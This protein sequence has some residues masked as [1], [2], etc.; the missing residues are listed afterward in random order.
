M[1]VNIILGRSGS[2][3]STAC[4][5][6]IARLSKTENNIYCI[7]PDGFSHKSEAALAGRLGACFEGKASVITFKRL[8][9]RIFE[10]SGRGGLVSLSASA[11]AMLIS[12]AVYLEQKNLSVYKNSAEKFGFSKKMLSQISELVRY[13]VTPDDI[14]KVASQ[15]SGQMLCDKLSDISKIYRRYISLFSKDYYDSEDD[16]YLA[17]AK[18]SGLDYLKD[19]SIFIDEFSDF[20]PSHY[21]MLEVIL[22]RAKNVSFYLCGDN[23]PF[24]ANTFFE[25]ESKT[26]ENIKDMCFRLGLDLK[27]TYMKDN[28]R[29]KK[30][31]DLLALEKNYTEYKVTPYRGESENIN[32]FEASDIFSELEFVAGEINHLCTKE[33]YK[34]S[35][36]CVCAGDI[37]LYEK[38]LDRCFEMYDIAYFKSD[39]TNVSESPVSNM[40]LSAFDILI[41]G[42]TYENVFLYLKSGFSGITDEETD[43]LENYVLEAGIDKSKWLSENDWTYKNSFMS[44]SV[45]TLAKQADQIRRKVIAPL[46][47]LK[48]GIGSKNTVRQGAKSIFE[49]LTSLEADKKISELSEEFKKD[50]KIV[51]SNLFIKAYN[52]IISVLDSLVDIAGDDKIGIKQM[53]NMLKSGFENEYISLIPQTVDE[54]LFCS[55]TDARAADCKLMFLVGTN[56]GEFLFTGGEEGMI[57][58]AEREKLLNLGIT[59]APACKNKITSGRVNEYK[60]LFK[61]D[62]RVYVTY[63]LSDFESNAQNK[64]EMADKIRKI[65]PALGTYS[66]LD[67]KRAYPYQYNS[68][69]PAYLNLCTAMADFASDGE[70]S[71]IWTKVYN[72]LKNDSEYKA[73][74][75]MADK[76]LNFKNIAGPLDNKL[77]SII[78][79]SGINSSVSRLETY[80]KCPFSYFI[81]YTLKA[82]ERKVLKI[83]LND[84]GSIMHNV[85]EEFIKT[86][87]EEKINFKILTEEEIKARLSNITNAFCANILKG[88]AADTKAN[89]YLLERIEKNLCRC[90]LVLVKHFCIGSF[91][92]V[93]CELKFGTEGGKLPAVEIVLDSG[94]KLKIHGVIDRLDKC[95][96]PNGTYYRVVD[97]KSGEKEFHLDKAFHGLDLQLAVYMC[98][99]TL[100]GGKAAAMFYFKIKEPM[101]SKTDFIDEAQAKREIENKMRLDG[102][103]L[104]DDDIISLMDNTG[105]TKSEILPVE[106]LKSGG[107]SAYSKVATIDEFDRIFAH[108]KAQLKKIGENILNG[109]IDIS[110]CSYS[111]KAPCDYCRYKA[112]CRFNAKE[113]SPTVLN[114][115]KNDEV[116]DAL[117]KMY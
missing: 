96:T 101:I 94:R 110:P 116:H 117:R 47:K 100:K 78:Y 71:I 92:P 56:T 51:Y 17:A 73:K 113:E 18:L 62:E 111:G 44:E 69:Y 99:A 79:K 10:K 23:A 21:K 105:F 61:A 48:E 9:S 36:I 74:I 81:E 52:G 76:A 102:L 25:N 67:K 41:D 75:A 19:A 6:E 31:P 108:T 11:K 98:A 35:D 5:N 55:A 49:F 22:K 24:K 93:E 26:V 104:A 39:K 4:Y 91:E 20:L 68:K 7:V 37:A 106:Y 28:L 72:I 95:E 40:L 112:V 33:G 13:G 90:A 64:S 42:F 86:C 70:K 27:I 2:G 29:H 38:A 77:L 46:I 15:F 43:I 83:G 80:R 12:R 63:S 60:A 109:K 57:S 65:I 53:K 114:K 82:K 115:M 107:Y 87:A 66:N 16:I 34:R 30:R 50:G 3:K 1:S 54:V 84:I 8:C 45:E 58:D 89:R 32:V 85:L 97:Y 14:D 59:L 88:S 103:V